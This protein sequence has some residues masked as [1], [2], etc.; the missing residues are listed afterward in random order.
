M[1]VCLSCLRGREKEPRDRLPSDHQPLLVD[2]QHEDYGSGDMNDEQWLH[3]QQELDAIVHKAN[4]FFIEVSGVQNTDNVEQIKVGESVLPDDIL[5]RMQTVK[6]KVPKIFPL[7]A[8]DKQ[9]LMQ[10]IQHIG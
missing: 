4:D 8:S 10:D 1:G 5:E 7:S 9:Q 3:R 2:D 6:L